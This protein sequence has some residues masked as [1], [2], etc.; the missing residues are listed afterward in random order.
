MHIWSDFRKLLGHMV[1]EW[2]IEVEPDKIKAILDMPMPRTK[3]ETKG[4]LGRL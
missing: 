1:S 3:R 4:F 2:G